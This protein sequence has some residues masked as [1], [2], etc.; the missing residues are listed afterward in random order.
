[1]N[2]LFCLHLI[3]TV[4][5]SNEISNTAYTHGDFQMEK[6]AVRDFENNVIYIHAYIH[7]YIHTYIYNIH[8]R[9]ICMCV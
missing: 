4:G 3:R 2:K 5:N 6:L 9:I 8:T 1:M 7:T